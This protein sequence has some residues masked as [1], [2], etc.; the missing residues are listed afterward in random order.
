MDKVVRFPGLRGHSLSSCSWGNISVEDCASNRQSPFDALSL[1]SKALCCQCCMSSLRTEH[2][3][4]CRKLSFHRILSSDRANTDHQ[5]PTEQ[6]CKTAVRTGISSTCVHCSCSRTFPP[7]VPARIH[8]SVN[9][10][11]VLYAWKYP[12][13]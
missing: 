12:I 8:L 4:S 7:Y 11:L 6:Y 10:G 1:T 2:N 3:L 13:R 9:L 5:V